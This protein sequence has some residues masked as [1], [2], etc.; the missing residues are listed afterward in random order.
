MPVDELVKCVAVPPAA[1]RS[2]SRSVAGGLAVCS[3]VPSVATVVSD[4]SFGPL[5]PVKGGR[6][7]P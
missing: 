7:P 3:L 2:S 1:A 4:L 6:V 5:V